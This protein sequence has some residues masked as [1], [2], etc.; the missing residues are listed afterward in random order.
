[1]TRL[2][3]LSPVA[4]LLLG[5]CEA[6]YVPQSLPADVEIQASQTEQVDFDLDVKP[7]SPEVTRLA[8]SSVWARK[9]IVSDAGSASGTNVRS[10]AN[11]LGER[12]PPSG[13]VPLYRLGIGDEV[14]FS[15]RSVGVVSTGTVEPSISA[16]SLP[17]LSDGTIFSARFGSVPVLGKTIEQVRQDV[18]RR[19][20]NET[21]ASTPSQLLPKPPFGDRPLYR[22]GAGD[23]VRITQ[24]TQQV[25]DEGTI[26]ET[27]S[28]RTVSVSSNGSIT[29]IGA[30]DI[31]V[32]GLTTDE[33]IQAISTALLRS[34]L[35]PDV[36]L[37]VTTNA[38][39]Q[40]RL[41]GDVP[42]TIGARVVAITE[43]PV[44]LVDLLS[45]GGMRTTDEIDYLLRINRA[46][47]EYGILASE[48]LFS[49]G[50]NPVYLHP[51]DVIVFEATKGTPDFSLDVASFAS[52]T[53][54]VTATS[55]DTATREI[56]VTAKPYTLAEAL[57]ASNIVV[58]PTKDFIARI[59]R[60]GTEY[61]VSARRVLVDQPGRDIYLVS[62][63]HIIIE[64]VNYDTDQVMIT[65]AA[66]APRLIPIEQLSRPSL[67]DAVF[68]SGALGAA[69]ADLKQVFLLRRDANIL[70]KFDAYYLDLSDP[71]RLALAN[72]L[73]LRPDDIIYVSTQP[74]SEFTG[75]V[76]RITRALG[77]GLGLASIL[78]GG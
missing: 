67:T 76:T 58:T 6:A 56:P 78:R 62:G 33:A 64:P 1:M 13:S 61:R 53:I 32:E 20:L 30:G 36:E 48:L 39:Q 41:V 63:D 16:V 21:S 69:E 27:T 55:A 26:S 28:T 49:G 4:L 57:R 24:L 29:L 3:L 2:F 14:I 35:P 10:A 37:T 74:V 15:T 50:D 73:Q 51:G 54:S 46:G 23:N 9:I 60:G 43:A 75:V 66:T 19:L 52:Q 44:K 65:G 31:S 59:S 7:I 18:A 11:G 17:V 8:N 12:L 5:A 42:S 72:E 71:T 47:R 40:V 45:Q 25:S 38:S 70:T 22:L 34:G 77:A 68:G